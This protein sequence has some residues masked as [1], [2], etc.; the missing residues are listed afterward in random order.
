VVLKYPSTAKPKPGA[1]LNR[2]HPLANG[3]LARYLFNE[4]NGTRLSNLC[5]VGGRLD[6]TLT[7]MDPATDWVGSVHGGGLDFDGVDDFA[8][9][10]SFTAIDEAASGS[11]VVRFRTTTAQN[12]RLVSCPEASAGTAGIAIALL[13][14]PDSVDAILNTSGTDGT[15]EAL[16]TYADGQW[17]QIAGTYDGA[18]VTVYYDSVPRATAVASGTIQAAS[19]ELN[20]GRFGSIGGYF[21]GQIDDVRIYKR[22]LTAFEVAQLYAD[23]YAD[24][25]SSWAWFVDRPHASLEVEAEL[26]GVGG[27]WTDIT[28]DVQMTPAVEWQKGIPGAAPLD[29]VA[30][31][32]RATFA[33]NNGKGNSANLQGYYSPKHANVRAGFALGIGVRIRYNI[34]STSYYKWRGT[35]QSIDPGFGQY[36]PQKTVCTAVDW[37]DQAAV[38]KVLLPV[39]I[40]RYA[41][42][43]LDKIVDAMPRQPADRDF[44]TGDSTFRYALDNSEAEAQPAMTELQRVTQSE[45][46]RLYLKGN[47]TG[48]DVLRFEKRTNRFSTPTAA[49]SF[50][51]TMTGLVAT[52]ERGRIY[53]KIRVT[54]HPRRVDAAATTVLFTNDGKPGIAAGETITINGRYTDPDLRASR[55]GGTDMVAP[56]ATT[57]YTAN[58]L[59]DGTGADLT[60]DLTVTATYHANSVD[61]SI[62]NASG[63]DG[64]ITKLQARGRGLYDYS[65]YEA[66]ATDAASVTSYG[67]TQLQYDMPY[68]HGGVIARAVADNLL[69]RWSNPE[70][71]EVRVTYTPP[72]TTGLQ[73]A[74]ALEPGDA[75]SLTETLTGVSS[76]YYIQHESVR[77][78]ES[79]YVPRFEWLCQAAIVIPTVQ[80]RATSSVTSDSMSHTVTLPSGIISG[81]LLI[82]AFSVDG[83]PTVTWPS[84]W[85]SFAS[86]N[87]PANASKLEI[88]Y[89]RADGTEGSSITVTTSASEQSTHSTLRIAG[90]EDPAT[91]A[92]EASTAASSNSTAPNSTTVTP[93]GDTKNYLWL[94]VFG[95]DDGTGGAIKNVPTGYANSNWKVTSTAAGTRVATAERTSRAAS[96]D[97][98]A[99][100][101]Q[102]TR[103]WVAFTVAVHPDA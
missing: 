18:T 84:G 99:W 66:I 51:D 61:Y 74:M 59:E 72:N 85:T 41:N 91:R 26:N 14:G 30:P 33:L 38:Y 79:Q 65:E 49:A 95:N 58:T 87:S 86:G 23:P 12:C 34:G 100:T 31:T 57:D 29:I 16:I 90:A 21:T 50:S 83:N 25:R 19:N 94:A 35:L 5:A 60:A 88:A 15:A 8:I 68:Q 71:T 78:G 45:Y 24:M 101:I 42:Q 69:S 48:G 7:S 4:G 70:V 22:A 75:L 76:L 9:N 55:V 67:E 80:S 40:D 28:T 2:G 46:G 64:F 10:S 56:A 47:T 43:I 3:L 77:F 54:V 103:D 6:A 17:H 20:I 96:E 93:T 62:T 73:T 97:P 11:I 82:S 92:P 1:Q 27:G 44:Q 89:R 32:G 52:E 102:V 13:T 53:N 98:G 36:G 63:S 81:D 37:F 39:Q